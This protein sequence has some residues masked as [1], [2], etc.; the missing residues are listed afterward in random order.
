ML[1]RWE[2]AD[3]AAASALALEMLPVAASGPD[4]PAILSTYVEYA[5]NGGSDPA[6]GAGDFPLSGA[7][8]A[9]GRSPSLEHFNPN[10]EGPS[11]GSWLSNTNEG[12][13]TGGLRPLGRPLQSITGLVPQDSLI[14]EA[15][16]SPTRSAHR[17]RVQ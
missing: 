1:R 3:L 16:P 4:Q 9:F 13:P 6:C 8:R 17:R 5:G 12:D 11:V 14:Q 10:A 7:Y 15:S 2:A